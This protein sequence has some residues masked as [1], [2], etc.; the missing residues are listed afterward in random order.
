MKTTITLPPLWLKWYAVAP[1][2]YFNTGVYN[3]STD[4][5]LFRRI[6]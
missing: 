5:Y 6:A 4:S 1:A 3:A 2:G